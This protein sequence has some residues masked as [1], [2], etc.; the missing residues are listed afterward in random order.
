[1]YLLPGMTLADI[2]ATREDIM[3]GR[4]NL[5]DP[6]FYEA[7]N[8]DTGIGAAINSLL[9][10]NQSR[11]YAA[12]AVVL[13]STI[14]AIDNLPHA[15]S[16]FTDISA[17]KLYEALITFDLIPDKSI[18]T[19]TEILSLRNNLKYLLN[20]YLNNNNFAWDDDR[21]CLGATAMRIVAAEALYAFNFPEDSDAEGIRSLSLQ[22]ME[23]NLSGSIDDFGA[24]ITDS[25]GFAD[26]AVEYLFVTAKAFKNAG[27][28]DTFSDQRLLKVMNYEILL[29]PPQQST[30]VKD[31]FMIAA[32]GE[33][34]PIE[35]HG[36][37]AVIAAA[38]IM[39]HD[40]DT[41]ARLMWFWNQCGK[42][43]NPLGLLFIN[44]SIPSLEPTGQ[45]RVTGGGTA[46]L[47]NNFGKTNESVIF[48]GFGN[49]YGAPDRNGHSFSD[50]GDFSFIWRGIPLIVHNG[51]GRNECINSL[52]NR[53]AWNHN[54]VLYSGAGDSPILPE[55]VYLQSRVR[56]DVTG[57]GLI[58]ADFYPDGI[59]Q[60]FSLN[61][62]DYVVGPVRLSKRDIPAERYYRHL[63]FLKPD[64]LL[65]WDQ[66]ESTF[67]L[68]WN[69]WI[70]TENTWSEK[71]I[72]HIHTV[73]N[74]DL[75]VHFAGDTKLDVRSDPYP[76]EFTGDW[77]LVMRSG[78]GNGTITIVCIDLFNREADD[79]T[80]FTS[81][82]FQNIL[83]QNGKPSNTGLIT[84]NTIISNT[85]QNLDISCET[86]TYEMV[87][88]RDLS[89]Y[90]MIVIGDSL[91]AQQERALHEVSWKIH[92][93]IRSGG[94]LILL[95]PMSLPLLY[96]TFSEPGVIPV[97]LA[98][99]NCPISLPGEEFKL[100]LIDDP[101]WNK[102]NTITTDAWLRWKSALEEKSGIPGENIEISPIPIT[103]SDSWT[104]LASVPYTYQIK[105]SGNERFGIP[106][107]IRV[108]HPASKDFFALFLPRKIDESTY[109]FDVKRSEP[110]SISFADPTTSWEVKAGETTWTDANLSVLITDFEGKTMYAF[111]CTYIRFGAETLKASAPMS[112]YYS[113]SESS[114]VI[115]S[116]TTNTI[117]YSRGEFRIHA[118]EIKFMNPLGGI[119]LER[120]IYVTTLNVVDDERIPLAFA[121]VYSDNR[122]IGATDKNGTLPV[123]WTGNPPTVRTVYRGKTAVSS[124]APGTVEVVVVDR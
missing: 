105:P 16:M 37:M 74:V 48:A 77:P 95:R 72:L 58:P 107:R 10:G 13:R 42:P 28:I 63:L 102:P 46:V 53:A 121:R 49:A 69:L 62:V 21:W 15:R 26:E 34:D 33:T 23:R 9:T 104:V 111:D 103:W 45:S 38:D 2:L 112:I 19:D 101:V 56:D 35:N 84:S 4:N 24:W 64:A 52:V 60:F 117:T 71:N 99:G 92:D 89:R 54:I 93:F 76:G 3:N 22:Y 66:I 115:M 18:F 51:S 44:T 97:T 118:G 83:S 61:Q 96:D 59:S 11:G 86:L 30:L 80:G 8:T 123:R 7:A 27:I 55:S 73:N 87:S 6:A 41:A 120:V 108:K 25:P 43:V 91:S 12:K 113:E 40:A 29:L 98:S 65:V 124:L 1:M 79:S 110:G 116:A 85:L 47:R 106:K 122:F 119:S 36:G 32:I 81:D 82:V 14:E 94:S 17:Q 50:H 75:Q 70:P 67:P 5:T 20:F 90:S 57:K 39:P 100:K 88:S 78:Y 68:E 109:L 31:A 114:G